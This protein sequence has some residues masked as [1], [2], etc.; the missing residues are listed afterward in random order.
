[1][2]K[3]ALV[4]D[5]VQRSKPIGEANQWNE[6]TTASTFIRDIITPELGENAN[7]GTLVSGI[8][9]AFA[10]V[11]LFKAAFNSLS[12]NEQTTSRNLV[13]YYSELVNEWRGFVAAIALDYTNIKVKRIDLAY[14]DGKTITETTNIYEP[15]GAFGNMLLERKERWCEQNVADNNV[16][17][18]YLNLIKYYNHVVGATAPESLLFTSSEYSVTEEELPWV[19]K[20]TYRFID[21]LRSDLTQDQVISLYAYVKHLLDKLSGFQKYFPQELDVETGGVRTNLEQWKRDIEEYA[22]RYNHDAIEA[23]AIPPVELDFSGPFKALFNYKDLLYGAEGQISEN[24]GKIE[25]AVGFNPRE[26]LLP[27]GAKIARIPLDLEFIKAPQKL[28]EMPI[29]MLTAEKKGS[30][31]E[32]AFFALPLSAQGLNVFGKSIGPLV[33]VTLE[34]MQVDSSLTAV[35]DPERRE[36]NLLV[37]LMI[38]TQSGTIRSYNQHYTTG[39]S[40]AMN[41]KDILI[42]PNFISKQWNKYYLYSELPHNSTMNTYKAFPF[43]G[44]PKDPFFRIL[45]D[46]NKNPILLAEQ[47]KIIAPEKMVNAELLVTSGNAVAENPYKYEIYRSDKPFKGIRLQA[48]GGEEGG[49]LIVNYT[50]EYDSHA[51]LPR[52]LRAHCVLEEVTVGFDFGSTNTSIAYSTLNGEPQG[53]CFTNQRVSLFGHERPGARNGLR[54]NK[55][56][57]F[58]GCTA[59]LKS[60][61]IHSVL[62]LHNANRLRNLEPGESNASRLSKEVVGGFPCFMDNLPVVSVTSDKICLRYPNIGTI[63]QIHNMKWVDSDEEKAHKKAYLCTLMLQVYAELFL[64]KKVPTA[65]RWSYPSS[66]SSTLLS[67]YKLI[68]DE[69]KRLQPVMKDDENGNYKVYPLEISMAKNEY[70]RNENNGLG[71]NPMQGGFGTGSK[72]RFGG[73]VAN[74]YSNGLQQPQAD[75]LQMYANPQQQQMQGYPQ[76]MPSGTR[77]MFGNSQQQAPV[78]P[79]LFPDQPNRVIEYHPQPLFSNADQFFSLTEANAVANF[80]SQKQGDRVKNLYLCF[81]IGGSTTDISALYRLNSGLTMIKQNSI[82]FAAQRVSEATRY[83][84]TGFKKVLTQSCENFN[85]TILGLNNGECRFSSETAPYYFNQIVDKLDD[86]QLPDF[87]NIIAAECPQLMWINMYVTGLLLFYAGQIASKLVDDIAHTSK[88]ELDPTYNILPNVTVVFAG[89]GSR[90]LQWLTTTKGEAGEVY[91][92]QLFEEGYIGNRQTFPHIKSLEIEYP[93]INNSED[94]KYEVSKGLA[95]STTQLCNPADDTPSEIIGESGFTVRSLD[96][97]IY[98]VEFVN[99]ISPEM[100]ESIGNRFNPDGSITGEKFFQFCKTF[101]NAAQQFFDMNVSMNV[102]MEGIQNMNI[103]QYVQNLPEF[104]EATN[105]K[106]RNN[107][108]DFVAPIIILEGMKFYD[109]YLLKSLR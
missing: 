76:Q 20:R 42:W 4:I 94:I 36:D 59:P 19:D 26:L 23:G 83:V 30:P 69:L 86:N 27:E 103:V 12:T 37:T 82:R 47:S 92:N 100:M 104:M 52:D 78:Y 97:K 55:V 45:T 72:S 16:K 3:K 44:D 102:F 65:V 53:F 40:E 51:S 39:S 54:E 77:S 15:T 91:Y 11:D 89:K 24:K 84:T 106:R 10:R 63:E 13:A 81:D 99:S 14:S 64:L 1:M 58:Q 2:E 7:V 33:G 32:Y 67:S 75:P 73:L 105:N 9:T 17:V 61:A 88:N 108:F 38:K 31:G 107:R 8:P 22:R 34:G 79:N 48:P 6:L 46:E 21:P 60:N 35:F 71:S 25:G 49:Y 93:T 5:V 57:F 85:I 96:D 70:N 101:Y 18:P 66:M 80:V 62:T 56:L 68:W 41:N 43:V 98:P 50:G 29:F 90:L 87:Y 109:N 74:P 28:K 95:K